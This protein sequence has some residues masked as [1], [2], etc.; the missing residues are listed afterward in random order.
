MRGPMTGVDGVFHL[1]GWYKIGVKDKSPA[2]AVNVDGTRNVLELVAELG[3]PSGVH[4]Y[5]RRV[6]PHAREGRQSSGMRRWTTSRIHWTS[7]R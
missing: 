1:V 6:R 5:A 2:R 4:E 7:L 3:V